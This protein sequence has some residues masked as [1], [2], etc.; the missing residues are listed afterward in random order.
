MESRCLS[1]APQNPI[2][3]VA[4]KPQTWISLVLEPGKSKIKA[5]ADLGSGKG[6][7]V[8]GSS[9][10]GGR[11]RQAALWGLWYKG[12]NLIPE[13]SALPPILTA[14]QRPP[15]TITLGI[16]FSIYEFGGG[17]GGEGGTQTLSRALG[18]GLEEAGWFFFFF[19]LCD[20]VFT[21]AHW[22][23]RGLAG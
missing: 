4:Y 8:A 14:S 22:P 7:L 5:L 21:W 17:S 9:S 6:Q 10:L 2:D 20:L 23:K 15:D 12:V 3:W 19:L 1:S 11:G 16:R 18:K 13:G